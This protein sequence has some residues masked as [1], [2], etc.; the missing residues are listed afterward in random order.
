MSNPL[1]D[2]YAKEYSRV[3]YVQKQFKSE[4]IYIPTKGTEKWWNRIFHDAL[5]NFLK[6]QHIITSDVDLKDLHNL[7]NSKYM[8]FTLWGPDHSNNSRTLMSDI[9]F[10]FIETHE[11]LYHEFIKWLYTDVIKKDFYF[12]RTPTTRVHMPNVEGNVIYPCWHADSFLGHNPRDINV[13]F[14][15]TDN[16]YSG[17]EV[18]KLKESQ[19]WF[20]EFKNDPIAWRNHCFKGD[21]GFMNLG[22]SMS[23]EVKDIYN[24][25]FLFDSRCI[26][27]AIHRNEKDMTTKMSI[28]VRLLLVEDEDWPMIDGEPVF[29]GSGIRKAEYKVGSPYGYHEKSASEL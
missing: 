12:Q 22:S 15:L 6:S 19:E 13:W 2:F 27:S 9:L 24:T 28:D 18:L 26:H 11:D 17:F 8:E 16:T 14:G 20:S 5:M 7:V 23:T 4:H 25:L 21:P 3:S 29:V 10:Q 1:C